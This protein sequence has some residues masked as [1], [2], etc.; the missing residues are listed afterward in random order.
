[1]DCWDAFTVFRCEVDFVVEGDYCALRTNMRERGTTASKM[2]ER[3]RSIVSL[4]SCSPRKRKTPCP[5][6]KQPRLLTRGM[7]V[8]VRPQ[9]VFPILEGVMQEKEY[10]CE[11]SPGQSSGR[12]PERW[13]CGDAMKVA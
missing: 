9:P 6:T 2:T 13:G 3:A 11:E 10:A 5:N 1:M 4:C 7:P 8:C 12:N